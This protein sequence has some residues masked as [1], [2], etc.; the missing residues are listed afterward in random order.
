[1]VLLAPRSA[2]L[3]ES[4]GARFTLLF[5]YV[6]CCSASSWM[7]VFWKEGIPYCHVG[8]A[9]ACIGAGVGLAGTP[10]SRS[11][12][13]A[14]P[15]R[16]AGMASGTADLQRDLGGAI[17]QSIFGA[18]LTAGYAAAF[19]KLIAGCTERRAASAP[20]CRA[21]SRSRSR[22]RRTPRSS[23]PQYASQIIEAAQQSF[24]DGQDWAYF[25]GHRRG[26]AWGWCSS[27]SSS[28]IATA[29]GAP[30]GVPPR[31]RGA[32]TRSPRSGAVRPRRSRCCR[33][34]CAAA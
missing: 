16:R 2:K 23:I 5:G 26:G 24:V 12:T 8:L 29:S 18:L 11:L 22:A 9:Y 33:S 4:H 19:S 28:R 1:M 3:V 25:A 20:R 31:G 17:M 30:R 6:F 15:V 13:G 34:T 27:S 32:R 14:V 21:S 10:A 7:L